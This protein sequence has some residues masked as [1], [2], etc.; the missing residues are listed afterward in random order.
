MEHYLAPKGDE[1]LIHATW[2]NVKGVMLSKRSKTNEHA[3]YTNTR[4]TNGIHSDIKQMGRVITAK[5]E[6]ELSGVKEM[7]CL[8]YDGRYITVYSLSKLIEL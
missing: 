7:F 5:S 2:M 6:R 8:D 4:M 1:L 3:L